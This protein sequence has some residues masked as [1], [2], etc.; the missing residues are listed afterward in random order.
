MISAA[1]LRVLAKLRKNETKLVQKL[2]TTPS[3]E[4]RERIERKLAVAREQI[5]R[6]E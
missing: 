5:S 2:E 4:D 6:A 3:A 1:S